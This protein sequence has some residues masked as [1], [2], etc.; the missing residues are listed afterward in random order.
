MFDSGLYVRTLRNVAQ[1]QPDFYLTL[2]DD[3][4]I[5]RL[6][7]RQR[8][9]QPAVNAAYARQ[10]DFLNT[11]G[12]STALFLVNGNHEQAALCN[13]DGT[14]NNP[15]VLAAVVADRISTASPFLT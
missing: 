13:L 6:I 15:A 5:E 11:L 9:S 2:G 8:L 1:D 14:S 10:R 4:S 3:F 12:R 7:E